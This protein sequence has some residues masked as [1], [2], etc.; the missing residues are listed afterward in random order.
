MSGMTIE[1]LE[2]AMMAWVKSKL[3]AG[4]VAVW[5]DQNAPKPNPKEVGLRRGNPFI[6]KVGRDVQGKLHATNGTRPKLGT[7]ELNFQARGYGKGSHQVLEDLK[8]LLDDET[9]DDLLLASA[10]TVF[11]TGDVQNLTALYASQ[12]KE[13][14]NFELRLRTHSLREGADA[15]AGVG[16]IQAVNLEVTTVDPAGGEVTEELEIDPDE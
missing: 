7:R 10:L 6:R 4:W 16:Y 3:P 13:V 8:T 2:N 15:E 12:L 14:G 9:T 1:T 5:E 11:D